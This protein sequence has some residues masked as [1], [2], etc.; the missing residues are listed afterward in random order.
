MDGI[1][2]FK[3]D[4]FVTG[5]PFNLKSGVMKLRTVYI[6]YSWPREYFLV[7]FKLL[8]QCFRFYFIWLAHYCVHEYSGDLFSY[9]MAERFGAP[10]SQGVRKRHTFIEISV[11]DMMILF[12]FNLLVNKPLYY[13]IFTSFARFQYCAIN[14]KSLG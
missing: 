14:L 7:A 12:D 11:A 4:F 2:L 13:E 9:Y 10:S 3:G 6:I 8:L 5:L 1:R